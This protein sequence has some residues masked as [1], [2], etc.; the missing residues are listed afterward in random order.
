MLPLCADSHAVAPEANLRHLSEVLAI[1]FTERA[2]R[3]W[4]DPG[5]RANERSESGRASARRSSGRATPYL[6]LDRPARVGSS[7]DAVA[8][9]VVTEVVR[10]VWSVDQEHPEL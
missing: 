4:P 1:A 3:S 2:Q 10:P 8:S 9:H 5:K 7:G 6:C